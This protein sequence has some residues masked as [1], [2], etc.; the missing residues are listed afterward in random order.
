MNV[1]EL[2]QG[3]RHITRTRRHVENEDIQACSRHCTYV[4]II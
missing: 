1:H 2:A 4:S 3:E